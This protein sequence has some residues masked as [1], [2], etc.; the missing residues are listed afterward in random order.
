MTLVGA[1]VSPYVGFIW[2]FNGQEGDKMIEDEYSGPFWVDQI[3]PE[4]G[5]GGVGIGD[6][7]SVNRGTVIPNGAIFGVIGYVDASAGLSI[8]KAVPVGGGLYLADYTLKEKKSYYVGKI[9]EMMQDIRMGSNSFPGWLIDAAGPTTKAAISVV[10][11]EAAQ[12]A[13]LKYQAVNS[14]Q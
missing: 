1:S 12:L 2:G 6:F 5:N 11:L 8:S 9:G 14:P 7:T 3:G 10:R 13:L 4:F